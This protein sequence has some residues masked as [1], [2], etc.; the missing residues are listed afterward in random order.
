MALTEA[1]LRALITAPEDAYLERKPENVNR[2]ELRRTVVAF[3]NS[4]TEGR[5]A[6]LF[7]GISDQG[8][9]L[10]VQNTDRK[11]IEIRKICTEDCYPP[12]TYQTQVLNVN[13]VHIVAVIIPESRQRPH[14]A[15]AAYIRRGSESIVA[16]PQLYEDLIAS[17]HEKCR[18]IQRWL[19]MVITVVEDRYRLDHGRVPGEWRA[20]RECM[21]LGCDAHTVRLKDQGSD[22]VFRV[23]LRQVEIGFDERQHR[24]QLTVGP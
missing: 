1:Q 8:Q 14:F 9:V 19:N 6:V 11:Q 15:G 5:D 4:V 23:S 20:S 2:E 18:V 7:I 17:R 13:S 21:V 24:H 12:I 16:T 10:G 3:A 22:N